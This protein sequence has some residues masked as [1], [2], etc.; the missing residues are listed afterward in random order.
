MNLYTSLDQIPF[1]ADDL[2]RM[3][4]PKRVLM[5]DPEYFAVDYVI[6]P[7]MEGHIGSVDKTEARKQWETMRDTLLHIGMEVHVIDGEPGLPDMVFCANQSLPCLRGDGSKEV[8]MSIMHA[9]QRK[10]EVTFVEN[11]YRSMDYT[12]HHLNSDKITDFEGM[13]DAIWHNGR[14]L[15]WGGYGYRSS[16]EAYETIS[17]VLN[18]PVIALEL[19]D[20]SFYHLDTCLCILNESSALYYPAAYTPE[21]VAILKAFFPNLIEV[22]TNEAIHGFACNALCPDGKNVLIHKDL[23][24]TNTTLES[25]G[26]KVHEIDTGEFLKS[27][28]SVFCMKMML[29]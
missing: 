13:G 3:Q 21:G 25:L 9:D 1:R 27:G 2:P 14:R 10:A 28:G 16:L 24:Q 22:S 20:P 29:W 11:F 17:S 12:I 4:T 23:N 18:V 7:H 6:N 15:I 19:V 8:V 26:F 5:V